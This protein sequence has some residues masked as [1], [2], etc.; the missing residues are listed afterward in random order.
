MTWHLGQVS[1][2]PAMMWPN[3]LPLGPNVLYFLLCAPSLTNSSKL[4]ELI[5]IKQFN[6]ERHT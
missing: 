4:V 6:I 2:Q 1:G 3:S 5:S